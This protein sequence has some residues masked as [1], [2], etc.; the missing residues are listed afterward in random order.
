MLTN[1]T[2]M[3]TSMSMLAGLSLVLVLLINFPI[4]PAVPFMKYDPADVPIL[5]GT[6][7][8]GTMGGLILTVFVS[9]FQGLFI[10]GDGGPI[11]I[12]MHILATGSFV[13]TAGCIYQRTRTKRAAAVALICGSLAMTVVMVACNLIFTPL[14]LGAPMEKVVEML[15]PAIVPFNLIKAGINAV[16]TWMI[17]KPVSRFVHNM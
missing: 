8:F 12:I 4:L 3:L 7:L 15:L 17:Y 9:V 16:L 14:F 1:K 2:R 13:V 11:G 6:F 10:S 5:I